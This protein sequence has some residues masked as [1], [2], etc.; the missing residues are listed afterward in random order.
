MMKLSQNYLAIL[1][2]NIL[3]FCHQQKNFDEKLIIGK[4]YNPYFIDYSEDDI[5][6]IQLIL[7][8]I[9]LSIEK[10]KL[11]KIPD[12]VHPT[13]GV[14]SD[15]KSFKT[16][17]EFIQEINN[18]DSFLYNYYTNTKK[19]KEI[20]NDPGQISLFDLIHQNQKIQMDFY[21]VSNNE[22]EIKLTILDNEKESYRFNNP[23]FI[24]VDSEWFIYRIP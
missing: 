19:L 15:L 13:K 9:F 12:Y 21:F 14:Y 17:E 6:K 24:K 23:Y 20:T 2:I 7:K 5:N 3:I 10:K 16:K 22:C 4:V 11:Q 8:D 18:P 1:V